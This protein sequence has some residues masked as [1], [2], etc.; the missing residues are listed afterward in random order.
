MDLKQ[1]TETFAH[2]MGPAGR[3]R[4]EDRDGKCADAMVPAGDTARET[5]DDG[6]YAHAVVPAG[7]YG[8]SNEYE[9]VH[10]N[11]RAFRYED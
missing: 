2:A 3:Y 7:R 8:E 6:K 9:S 5:D 4:D 10:D 11:T 1:V